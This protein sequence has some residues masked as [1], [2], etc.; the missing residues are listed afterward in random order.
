MNYAVYYSVNIRNIQMVFQKIGHLLHVM[1]FLGVNAN[2]RDLVKRLKVLSGIKL[3]S[4][5]MN[6]GLAESGRGQ[7]CNSG[8]H[9]IDVV[10]ELL[11][12]GNMCIVCNGYC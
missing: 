11:V 9:G 7:D 8:C 6:W 4:G 2:K 12:S 5:E 3:W 1:F 10:L